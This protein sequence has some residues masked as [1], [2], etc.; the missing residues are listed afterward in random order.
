MI[1]TKLQNYIDYEVKPVIKIKNSYGYRV[2]LKYADGTERVRQKSGF[3]SVK[4]ATQDRDST[5]GKL[6]GGTYCVYENI[7]VSEFMEFWLEN[8]IKTRVRSYETYYNFKGIV[9]NH[10]NPY[11]GNKKIDLVSKSDIQSL[12]N[13]VA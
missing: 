7:K 6:F 13:T 1:D 11:L 12:Y 10:I 5:V 8:D 9:K 2:I 3:V 4:E